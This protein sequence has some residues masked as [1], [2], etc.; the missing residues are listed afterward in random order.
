MG[1]GN[2]VVAANFC[3]FGSGQNRSK[4]YK[5]LRERRIVQDLYPCR[6]CEIGF[7]R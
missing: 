1:A 6:G 4:D 2:L 7:C 5:V 3:N